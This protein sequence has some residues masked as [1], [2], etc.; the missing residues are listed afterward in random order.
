M[1]RPGT[2]KMKKGHHVLGFGDRVDVAML[3]TARILEFFCHGELPNL[4]FRLQKKFLVSNFIKSGPLTI[5]MFFE[6]VQNFDFV[7]TFL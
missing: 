6:L 4:N 1:A 5:F 2:E 7:F 3:L